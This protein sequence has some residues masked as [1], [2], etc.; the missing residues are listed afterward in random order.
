MPEMDGVEFVRQL[1]AMGY[2][3]ELVPV[4]GEDPRILRSSQKLTQAHGLRVLGSLLKPPT[5]EQLR[6]RLDLPASMMPAPVDSAKA[7]YQPQ[8]LHA[9]I[10]AGE[11]VNYYQPQVEIATGALVGVEALVRWQHPRDGIVA[12]QGFIGLAEEHDSSR[13]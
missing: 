11:I 7:I 5:R 6:E 9:A 12:A 4:S 1:T 3:G 10:A 2:G 8:E 13:T